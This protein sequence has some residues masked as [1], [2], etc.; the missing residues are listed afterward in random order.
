MSADLNGNLR[1]AIVGLGRMGSAMATR[2]DGAGFT[3]LGYDTIP[4]ARDA[5]RG[6]GLHVVDELQSLHDADVVLSSLPDTAAVESSY[7]GPSKL[8]DLL[9]PNATCVDL[10]TIAPAASARIAAIA[11][12]RDVGFLDAPVSGSPKHVASGTAALYIGGLAEH[13][14][15]VDSVLGSFSETRELIGLHGAGLRLKLIA[16][17]LF[18]T[19][20]A[21][22]AESIQELEALHLDVTVG[23]RLLERGA[24]PKLLSYKAQPMADHDWTPGFT[25]SLMRKDL[26]LMADEVAPGSLGTLGLGLIESAYTDGH[27]DDDVGTLLLQLPPRTMREPFALLDQHQKGEE[28]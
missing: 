22:I 26:R 3:V 6:A 14:Q 19:H 25:V 2:V 12:T 24:V 20:L 8:L 23:L 21:A 15:R 13:L 5:A 11:Q 28:R 17:R 4:S 9:R 10:S 18:T 16:N 27:A 1:V 7:V